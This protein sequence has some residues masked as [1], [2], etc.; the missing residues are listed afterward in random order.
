M[1]KSIEYNGKVYTYKDIPKSFLK[2]YKT[3]PLLQYINQKKRQHKYYLDNKEAL[4][5]STRENYIK[6]KAH[7]AKVNKKRYDEKRD[8]IL[9]NRKK[10]YYKNRD[11]LLSKAK[12]YRSKPEVSERC[13]QKSKAWRK[14]NPGYRSPNY[15]KSRE[16]YISSDKGKATTKAYT[17]KYTE[18]GRAAKMKAIRMSNPDYRA[19][20]SKWHKENSKRPEVMK[21]RRELHYI[22]SKNNSSYAM[23]RRLRACLF[24]ALNLYTKK[25][26]VLNSRSYG[27]DYS[28]CIKKLSEDAK[29]MGYTLE[30]IKSMDY[31][32]DHIIPISIYNLEDANE[33]KKCCNP[34]NMRWLKSNENI[35]K[36]NKL[37]PEDIEVIKT[38]P[39]DIYPKQWNGVIPN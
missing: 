2:K 21:R 16:K 3:D 28:K 37:R 39:T 5:K 20:V 27:L 18:S 29:E 7:Y 26:K 6:N 15:D 1:I 24:N 17:K 8:E 34:E 30:E 35:V 32:I 23:T 9:R 4:N 14:D 33:V 19:E 38:L 12:V 25:G 10:Y 11:M 36:G 13:R 31:H 22:W